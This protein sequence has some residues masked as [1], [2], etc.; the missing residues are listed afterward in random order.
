[1]QEVLTQQQQQDE[2]A[3][4]VAARDV[5]LG[6]ALQEKEQAL[7]RKGKSSAADFEAK[8]V[9]A[10]AARQAQAAS[11]RALLNAQAEETAAKTARAEEKRKRVA[12]TRQ[13][14]AALA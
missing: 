6:A 14:A 7:K 9:E 5:A 12:A 8:K 3:K 11:A 10:Q 2:L 13:Q 1:M 4:T